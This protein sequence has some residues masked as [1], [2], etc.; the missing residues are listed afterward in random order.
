M[1]CFFFCCTIITHCMQSYAE[2][3]LKFSAQS[4][5]YTRHIQHNIIFFPVWSLSSFSFYTITQMPT[6]SSTYLPTLAKNCKAFYTPIIF[7]LTMLS[8]DSFTYFPYLLDDDTI[9]QTICWL[10]SIKSSS[11]RTPS[12]K[13]GGRGSGTADFWSHSFHATP[14]GLML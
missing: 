11:G 6:I 10:Q 4:H 14:I 12:I 2:R 1:T 9:C 7:W 8:N 13:R 3:A 5:H